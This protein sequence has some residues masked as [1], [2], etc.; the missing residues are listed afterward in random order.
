MLKQETNFAEE[1]ITINRVAVTSKVSLTQMTSIH[2]LFCEY[3]NLTYYTKK[4]VSFDLV[5]CFVCLVL[6]MIFFCGLS[7]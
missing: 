4:E 1:G 3:F 6:R 5:L 7:S 2:A